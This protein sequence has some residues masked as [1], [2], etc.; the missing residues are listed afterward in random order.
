[1]QGGAA[2]LETPSV[3]DDGPL[4]PGVKLTHYRHA[5]LSGHRQPHGA[6][7]TRRVV[8]LLMNLHAEGRRDEE[9]TMMVAT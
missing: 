5:C 6:A 9:E 4:K 8:P 3:D 2:L 7:A 1:M